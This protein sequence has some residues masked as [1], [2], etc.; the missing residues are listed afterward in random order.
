[1][2]RFCMASLYSVLLLTAP[3]ALAASRGK[4][5]GV[6]NLNEASITQLRELP[7]V[8]EKLAQ[9]IIEYR[10]S[11]K[12]TKVEDLANVEGFSPVK[13]DRLKS[14]LSVAGE[15]TI[16]LDKKAKSTRGRNPHG[17]SLRQHSS[18]GR[19]SKAKHQK[20][21]SSNDQRGE[22]T[23]HTDGDT[24]LEPA[25]KPR[26][27]GSRAGHKV[28]GSATDKQHNG[29]VPSARRPHKKAGATAHR[30]TSGRGHRKHAGYSRHRTT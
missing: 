10:T 29:S 8:S 9:R 18:H 24:S 22:S 28:R 12:F 14:H 19:S 23:L 13:V 5:T 11:H 21:E 26:S 15:S 20:H 3:V 7:G 2:R 27:S 17:R 6:A 25:S 1:M 16:Q 4:V 30:H